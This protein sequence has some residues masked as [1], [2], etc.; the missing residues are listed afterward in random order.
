MDVIRGNLGKGMAC[1]DDIGEGILSYGC[2]S[3]AISV[4]GGH[5]YALHSAAAETL[6][7]GG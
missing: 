1:G 4:P 7:Q 6:T 3:E 5:P 2:G